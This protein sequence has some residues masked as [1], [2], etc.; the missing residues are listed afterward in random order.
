MNPI[1]NNLKDQMQAAKYKSASRFCK[2]CKWC[3]RSFVDYMEFG[4]EFSR[5]RSPNT[6]DLIPVGEALVSGKKQVAGWRW[7][8]CSVY[9]LQDADPKE[10]YCGKQGIYFEQKIT[11]FD[12]MK[13]LWGKKKKE[14]SHE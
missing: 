8:F 10:H 4:W 5:C 7:L 1:I 6:R 12:K 13:A 14:K 2:N 9:R 3:Q 11:L